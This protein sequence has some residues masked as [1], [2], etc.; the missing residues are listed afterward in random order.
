[1]QL[2]T[3]DDAG[4]YQQV[5]VTCC[6]H[7]PTIYRMVDDGDGGTAYS[8][9]GSAA[10]GGRQVPAHLIINDRAHWL[11]CRISAAGR[12]CAHTGS[13][14]CLVSLAASAGFTWR[15]A[16]V[17]LRSRTWMACRVMGPSRQCQA[18]PGLVIRLLAHQVVQDV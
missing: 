12:L 2:I 8:R 10:Q 3:T 6:R 11:I 7:R 1:M 14:V 4:L 5:E 9:G 18:E 17:D 16:R 15:S 13:M